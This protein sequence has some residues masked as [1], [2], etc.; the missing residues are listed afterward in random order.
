[1]APPVDGKANKE[2]LRFLSKV[3][4]LAKNKVRLVS[5]ETNRQKWIAFTGI[6]L[7]ELLK[8][9]DSAT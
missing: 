4:G 5:G 8:R 6:E 3:S 7:T 2:L 1:M 9:I